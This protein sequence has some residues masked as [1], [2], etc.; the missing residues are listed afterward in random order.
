M[1]CR[2]LRV[3]S[4]L[5]AWPGCTRA[6]GRG[7]RYSACPLCFVSKRYI[8]GRSLA[9]PK[10]EHRFRPP[11]CHST[12][13]TQPDRPKTQLAQHLFR[14][15]RPRALL[16]SLLAHPSSC[17]PVSFTLSPTNHCRQRHEAPGLNEV[18]TSPAVQA[19][20]TGPS[21]FSHRHRHRRSSEP[22]FL[23]RMLPNPAPIRKLP[24]SFACAFV[25]KKLESTATTPSCSP[26]SRASTEM[27]DP[28]T[29]PDTI[30]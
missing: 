11:S 25:G 3:F 18:D 4:V 2:V 10:L 17:I 21:L 5:P 26:P 16:S 8:P 28:H 30:P 7:P 14:Q 1:W 29:T 27:D 20:R 6:K 12:S 13:I 9:P 23:P 24:L 22:C 15:H 19:S